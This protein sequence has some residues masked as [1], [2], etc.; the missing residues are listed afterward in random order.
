MLLLGGL[1]STNIHW[2]YSRDMDAQHTDAVFPHPPVRHNQDTHTLGAE[3]EARV[4][5][6]TPSECHLVWRLRQTRQESRN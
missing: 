4:F 2:Y 1:I 6:Y 5:G 3:P